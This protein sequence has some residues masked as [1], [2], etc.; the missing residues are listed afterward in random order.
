MKKLLL[1]LLMIGFLF[2]ALAPAS[3]SSSG[4]RKVECPSQSANG[5]TVTVSLTSVPGDTCQVLITIVV[6]CG[7]GGKCTETRQVS[8]G[9]S[10]IQSVKC[11]AKN[12]NVSVTSSTWGGV[13]SGDAGCENIQVTE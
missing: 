10:E 13:L 4:D 5:C 2:A 3:A 1:P 12:F 8:C 7:D 9:S 11:A 6:D